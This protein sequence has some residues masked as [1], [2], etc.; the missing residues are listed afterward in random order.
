MRRSIER[1]KPD[2]VEKIMGVVGI[3]GAVLESKGQIGSGDVL[4]VPRAEPFPYVSLLEAGKA[5]ESRTEGNCAGESNSKA[6]G[7]LIGV[8][9][10]ECIRIHAG[11]DP[12]DNN[13]CEAGVTSRNR[14]RRHSTSPKGV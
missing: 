11:K 5:V 3:R 1:P 7:S 12:H 9:R 8:G 14:G 4:V 2:G 6:V 10:S 13:E